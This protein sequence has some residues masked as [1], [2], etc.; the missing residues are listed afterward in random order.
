MSR[1]GLRWIGAVAVATVVLGLATPGFASSL[2]WS[3][4]TVGSNGTALGKCDADG[5]GILQNLS[6]A[7]VVSV[8]VSGI[9][10]ACAGGT[11]SATVDNATTASSG[12]A[13]VPSGGGSVTVSLAASVPAK[14]AEEIDVAISGP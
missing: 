4:R 2:G 8:T 14:D 9:A 7:N 10:A 13:V 11:L 1:R 12:T 6:G 3:S 5:V